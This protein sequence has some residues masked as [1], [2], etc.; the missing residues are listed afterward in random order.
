MVRG[1]PIF[2]CVLVAWIQCSVTAQANEPLASQIDQLIE[3]KAAE[4]AFGT[5]SS[6]SDDAEFLRRVSLDLTGAIPTSGVVREFLSDPGPD[7]RTKLIDQL[8][9]GADY[10]R[11]MQEL[12]N[13]LL[14]ERLG[15]HAEWQKYLQSSFAQNK[16]WD[17]MVR[18]M[19]CPDSEDESVRGA[20]F[21]LSKRLENYGQNP[22]D[23]PAL[24]RDIGRLFLGVD[25]QCAQCHDHLFI[26]DYKQA[27]FQGIYTFVTN[28]AVRSDVPFPAVIEK[29]LSKKTDFISVFKR[30]PKSIGPKLPGMAEI[31]IP[32]FPKDQE[33]E[34]APDPAK[35]FLGKLKF[36]P[37]K[38]LSEQLPSSSNPLFARNIANRTWAILMGR[39]IIH[40]LDLNH[41]D[42]PPSHP[43][44]LDLLAQEMVAHQFDIKWLIREICLSRAYQR[45]SQMAAGQGPKPETFL[46]ALEKPLA[47]EQVLRASLQATG[48]WQHLVATAKDPTK[49]IP[50]ELRLKFLKAFANP[51]REPE[52]EF[53]PS[54]KTALFIMHD[55]TLQ[56]WLTPQEGRLVQ[57]LMMISD[58]GLIAEELYLSVLSRMPSDEERAEVIAALMS[59][60]EKRS[61]VLENLTWA[62]LATTE[63]CVNH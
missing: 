55:A 61:K 43:E 13:S 59:A 10:P 30:E 62:L 3:A 54:V 53:A 41:A 21:F 15:E 33:F 52:G 42:N 35:R 38:K 60:G 6:L 24:T 20:A 37:L 4:K 19:L 44:L 8:L 22:V 28:T 47:A 48:E 7:K 56:G 40:P 16:H 17:Q 39:G 57:Q 36:S 1:V 32:T 63:F 11:R 45:S 2:V 50:D 49:P 14:M 58:P 5:A 25:L 26:D 12:F 9:A 31:E 29:P 34:V 51:P 46:V 27:D 18:E 23:R